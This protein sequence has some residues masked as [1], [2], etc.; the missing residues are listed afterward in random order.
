MADGSTKPISKVKI[1]DTVTATD[2][3]N[4]KLVSKAVI[5]RFDDLD[6]DMAD[7]TVAE[8]HHTKSGIT[9]TKVVIHTTQNHPFWDAT[10]KKWTRADHLREG[11]HLTPANGTDVHVTAVRSFSQPNHRFNLT[12]NDLHT[13]YVLAGTT[14]V[15]VHNCGTGKGPAADNY[16]GRYNADQAAN[17]KPRLPADYD[18]H[19]A[20]PQYYRDHPEF[21]DFDFDAP[22]NIRGVQGSRAGPGNNV[23]QEITNL[24]SD[25]QRAAPNASRSSI[26]WFAG[27]IDQT[28]GHRFW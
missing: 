4:G 26:E 6:T 2:P 23:H 11:D 25:F 16:R 10:N 12:V 7:V 5:A 27:H 21:E 14:P 9:S 17:G 18:A 13:Y 3:A 28:Y 20:V 19:H 8:T 1:G 15:L 24:W 22:S